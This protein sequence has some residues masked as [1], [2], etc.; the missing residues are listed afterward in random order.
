MDTLL[1]PARSAPKTS[2]GSTVRTIVAL[3]MILFGG[4]ASHG[5]D[6]LLQDAFTGDVYRFFCD[7]AH[8]P[9][10]ASPNSD[11]P[12]TPNAGGQARLPSEAPAA[13]DAK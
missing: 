10:T 12:I 11:T 2:H 3:A 6:C 1:H 4:C 8:Q 5:D 7:R 13:V 9:V